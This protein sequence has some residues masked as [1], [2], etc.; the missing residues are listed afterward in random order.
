MITL[1]YDVVFGYIGSFFFKE[2]YAITRKEIA[3]TKIMRQ[4][5]VG[6]GLL[7]RLSHPKFRHPV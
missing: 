7:Q 1:L 2:H 5:D 3:D 4:Y 6:V